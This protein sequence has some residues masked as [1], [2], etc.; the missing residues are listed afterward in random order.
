MAPVSEEKVQII[1]FQPNLLSCEEFSSQLP[2]P[3]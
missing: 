2:D 3:L 1:I